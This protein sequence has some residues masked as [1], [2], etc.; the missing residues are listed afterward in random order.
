MLKDIERPLKMAGVHL[1]SDHSFNVRGV[2]VNGTVAFGHP[3]QWVLRP[4]CALRAPPAVPVLAIRRQ[5][6]RNSGIRVRY[7]IFMSEVSRPSAVCSL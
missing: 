1:F 4:P 5:G 7:I 3:L 6:V 2:T